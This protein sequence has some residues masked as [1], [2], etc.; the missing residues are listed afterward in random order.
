MRLDVQGLRAVAIAL[1]VLFH[2]GAPIPGGFT[3]VDVFFAISGFVIT[4]TLATELVERGRI[5]LPRFYARRV[6]R[7]LP[8]LAVMVAVVAAAGALASP[9]QVQPLEARTGIWAAF[10]AA[11]AYLYHLPTGY[12]DPSTDLNPFLH[13]WTLA[14]EEQFYVV[15]PTLLVVAWHYGRRRNGA[16]IAAVLLA[17]LFSFAFSLLFSYGH[18]VSSAGPFAFY[19]LPTRAWEFGLGAL[20]AL[21]ASAIARLPRGAAEALAAAGI[22]LILVGAFA[23]H[24]TSHFPGAI[25]LLPVGGAVLLIAGGT[26]ARTVVSR[27]LGL[28]PVTWI[29]DRSYSW[30]LWHWPFIVDAKALWPGVGW[31]AP[32]AAVLSLAPAWA[33]YR[34]VEN[35]IRFNHGLRGR[36][37]LAL[38]ALAIAL[39][40]GACL[41]LLGVN[42]RLARMPSLQVWQRSQ[43]SHADILRGCDSSVPLGKR[44][45][46][47][48]TWSVSRPR[49]R[50][51]LIGDSN[52][53]HFTEP[54][55]A[56][57]NRA[58]Y[59]V[60]VA[61]DSGC[62]FVLVGIEGDPGLAASCLRFMRG[63]LAAILQAKP[64]LVVTAA[65]PDL[66]IENPVYGVGLIGGRA[67]HAASEKARLWERGLGQ[68]LRRLNRAGIPVL[69]VHPVPALPATSA[70]C[71]G[72]VVRVLLHGSC[73]GE[74]ARRKID[75][76][77]TQFV[78]L[79]NRAVRTASRSHAVDFEDA[80]C[81][82]RLCYAVRNGVLM[83]R[84]NDHLSVAGA[85]TL[86]GRFFQVIHR[87][88][89]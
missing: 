56:A 46:P 82:R 83:Y 9:L 6:K 67:T 30:Y 60:V 7:L 25:A 52:A 4:R 85:Q 23:I 86:T 78:T 72:A 10:F 58:G 42:Q 89:R 39:P 87:L 32:V 68:I 61:T 20:L 5:D 48:C 80:L 18:I 44:E 63:S 21:S 49:G 45:L 37:V 12:F 11:N 79:E 59:D 76:G 75:S 50:I 64:T 19:S 66:Y 38:A 62:P 77:L 13:T 51:V 35:P 8:A 41:L 73:N 69:L 81:D 36:R 2:A 27:G 65:R 74:T 88:L 47:Q 70:A 34:F 15:F 53:G 71:S 40:V 26:A 16:A 57:G 14:V 33:S 29:G 54:V 17:S 84:D 43:A 55:V 31:A 22:G 1:V 28:R 24:G 3:G